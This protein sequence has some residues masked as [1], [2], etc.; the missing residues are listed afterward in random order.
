MTR[1]PDPNH[2]TYTRGHMTAIKTSTTVERGRDRRPE[3]QRTCPQCKKIF[4]TRIVDKAYCRP[5]C[6][7]EARHILNRKA[8]G[9]RD[10]HLP[11]GVIGAMHELIVSYDLMARGY[12]VFRALSHH[13]PVDL[14]AIKRT[15]LLVEVNKQR[16]RVLS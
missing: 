1:D 4:V 11:S 10:V 14:V 9:V 3:E 2:A 13:C 6:A 5:R 12:Y 15:T 7:N 8:N 16:A